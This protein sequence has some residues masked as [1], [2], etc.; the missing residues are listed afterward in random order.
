[1]LLQFR[2]EFNTNRYELGASFPFKRPYI[3]IIFRISFDCIQEQF[4]SYAKFNQ[5][6]S[7]YI[8][9]F[10][11]WDYHIWLNNE[12]WALSTH[13]YTL[14]EIFST[15]I[16]RKPKMLNNNWKSNRW[17]QLWAFHF[18]PSPI[19]TFDIQFKTHSHKWLSIKNPENCVRMQI[20]NNKNQYIESFSCKQLSS[21]PVLSFNNIYNL[22]VHNIIRV[23]C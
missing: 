5:Q 22:E 20:I 16:N 8:K 17:A 3:L 13:P 11:W 15:K 1:M 14:W 6:I 10:A 4:I 9:L 23:L 21:E 19:I 2:S 7:I 12:H 18:Q